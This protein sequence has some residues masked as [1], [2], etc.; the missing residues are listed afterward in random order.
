M[1]TLA[2][3]FRLLLSL[4]IGLLSWGIITGGYWYL[5]GQ[6][7][8]SSNEVIIALL[9]GAVLGLV[10]GFTQWIDD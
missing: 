9:V 2:L 6:R 10:I 4:I 3:P 8:L 5:T 7:A 1:F